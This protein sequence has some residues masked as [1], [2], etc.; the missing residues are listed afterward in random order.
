MCGTDRKLQVCFSGG[1]Q[2]RSLQIQKGLAKLIAQELHLPQKKAPHPRAERLG[3]RLLGAEA[4]R[5][6]GRR[7]PA[8]GKLIVFLVP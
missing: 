2:S 7:E 3:K 4:D 8:P 1:L 6:A 5:H